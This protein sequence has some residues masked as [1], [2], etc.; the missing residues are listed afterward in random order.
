M[1]LSR[2]S[3]EGILGVR[4]AHLSLSAPILLLTGENGAG[5]SS[6]IEAV[7]QAMTGVV[8]RT[9]IKN[10]GQL[11]GLLH[12][13]FKAGSAFLEWDGGRASV[14]LPKGTQ[15][16]EF[17]GLSMA[18]ASVMQAALPYTLDPD[19]FARSTPDQRREFL[20]A[21][22]RVETTPKAVAQ[23]LADRGCDADKIKTV[24]PLTA[25]SFETA[26]GEAETKSR[27]SK[28]A[29]RAVAGEAYGGVKA[30][31][32]EAAKP[33]ADPA[34]LQAAQSKVES[35]TTEHG[36][37]SRRA[38]E[39]DG[40]SKSA[41]EQAVQLA[42]LR[43]RAARKPRIAEKL[44]IDEAELAKWTATVEETRAKASGARAGNPVPCPHCAALVEIKGAVLHPYEPPET[45]ADPDAAAKLPEYERSLKLLETA[46]ANDKRDLADA[47]AAAGAISALEASPV[48]KPTSAEVDAAHREV[49]RI[50]EEG[51]KARA[52]LQTQEE[53]QRQ[54][55]AADKKTKDA[56]QHHADVKAWG[57][58]IEA[59]SPDG[60][61][62]QLMQS[63][64]DPLNE[65]LQVA[66]DLSSWPL[67]Q[68]EPDM[69]ITVGGREHLWRSESEKWRANAMLAE[70]IAF[71]SGLRFMVLD[72]FDVLNAT[73]RNDLI[74]WLDTLVQDGEIGTVIIAGTLKAKPS[75]LPSTIQAE[76][77]EQ[78]VVGQP[79][80]EAA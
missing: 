7:K 60:I 70:A 61:P 13:D 51:K 79:I 59:L 41:A 46:V 54:A 22:M 23:M 37:A 15:S 40:Q 18:Q 45:L 27:E 50:I 56:T 47:E 67:V 69:A 16:F 25:S 17:P 3:I 21:M 62:A 78:G 72:R 65:R 55:A 35:L 24:A 58:L 64:L 9:M 42:G 49:T 14:I 26:L 39:L 31:G 53:A 1:E 74:C 76:W 80:A 32:W 29:W 12:D 33:S 71:L 52:E 34:A 77:I 43:E 68:I 44:K 2:I 28:A 48:T 63:A 66:A 11:A 30:E 73:G 75:G 38:G 36:N 5:K 4:S 19:L 10:K 6:I 20:Y 8:T 57:K